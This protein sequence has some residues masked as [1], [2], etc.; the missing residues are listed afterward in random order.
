MSDMVE[1]TLS[2]ESALIKYADEK[3]EEAKKLNKLLEKYNSQINFWK[4]IGKK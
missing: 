3:I 2:S 4:N 1:Y